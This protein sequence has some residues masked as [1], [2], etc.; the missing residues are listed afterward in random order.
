VNFRNQ[1]GVSIR[2]GF[3]QLS[4]RLNLMQKALR[5]KMTFNVNLN[6]LRRN[7]NLGFPDAFKYAA[8]YN[9]TSPI[10]TDSSKYDLGGAGFLRLTV[11]TTQILMRCSCKIVTMRNSKFNLTASA[12]YEF[13]KG[14][15]G[16][17]RYGQ[18]TTSYYEQSYFPPQ[19]GSAVTSWVNGRW[20]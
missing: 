15:K 1:E 9:P 5:D 18:Q 14:L 10:Y 8:I 12:D 19:P 13:F 7:A 17:V 6:M 2:T 11:L 20:S 16:L 3:N 4:G